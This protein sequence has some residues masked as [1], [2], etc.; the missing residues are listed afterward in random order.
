M[1]DFLLHIVIPVTVKVQPTIPGAQI[2]FCL[3]L[4]GK[5]A[6]SSRTY[7]LRK[8]C[9][10]YDVTSNL[11]QRRHTEVVKIQSKGLMSSRSSH[12][13]NFSAWIERFKS[14]DFVK[15]AHDRHPGEAQVCWNLWYCKVIALLNRTWYS[16]LVIWNCVEYNI[17]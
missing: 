8:T 5:M 7:H 1:N 14:L 11:K 13:S 17:L 3:L 15:D 9:T 4:E 12:S 2:K 10:N 6:D 16:W